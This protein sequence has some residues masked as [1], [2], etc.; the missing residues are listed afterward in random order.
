MNRH[1]FLLLERLGYAIFLASVSRLIYLGYNP[2]FHQFPLSDLGGALLYGLLFDLSALAYLNTLFIVIHLL[3]PAWIQARRIQVIFMVMYLITQTTFLLLNLID[4]GYY[5]FAGRR[6]S[7]EL[8]TLGMEAQGMFSAYLRDYWLLFVFLLSMVAVLGWLYYRTILRAGSSTMPAGKAWIAFAGTRLGILGLTFLAMRGGLHTI[9]LTPIDA[10][11]FARPE[12]VALVVNTP[13]NMIISSQQQGLESI[14]YMPENEAISF[15]NPVFSW[16]STADHGKRNIVI[17]I[18]ESLGSEYV[19]G[20]NKGKGYTPF[21][22]SLMKFSEV[23][24]H[25]YA[26]GKKSI[27]GV[28]AVLASIPVLMETPYTTSYYQSNRIRGIGSYLKDIG[29]SASFYHGGKNGTMGFDNFISI[30]GGGTYSGKDQYP[31]QGHDDGHWGIFDLPYL[32]FYA[33]ELSRQPA[34]FFSALFTLSSHH[35][36]ALP[37]GEEQHFPDGTLPIHK[38]IRYTDHAL[39]MFFK[40][41]ANTP[42]YFN[43]TFIITAD[44]SSE[45]ETPYYQSPHGKFCI[46]L[47]IFRPDHPDPRIIETSFAQDD[48]LAYALREAGYNQSFFS[49][50]TWRG[51]AE[52]LQAVLQ[53]TDQYYQLIHWPWVYQFDGAQSIALYNISADSLMHNN[54]L[55]KSEWQPKLD[56]L[57]KFTQAMIQIMHDRIIHNRT[58]P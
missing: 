6:S 22:D 3:P 9:P 42:W 16:G 19:G 54:L 48:I 38:T 1:I 10:A 11:R 15:F 24:T 32:Q 57:S 55:Q 12:L 20:Y 43:T 27:E 8:F 44:H 13:F 26:N 28:P 37:A 35:P 50:G 31:Y 33:D 23:F 25:A 45:N 40:K 56:S 53:Y 47:I 17:L 51:G 36:Y 49:F 30:S 39:R 41:A 34:P 5:A 58:I 14:R 29:Y 52:P 2:Y 4:T 7:I 21:L 18:V 46:P